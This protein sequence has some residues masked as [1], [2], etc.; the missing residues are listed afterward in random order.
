VRRVPWPKRCSPTAWAEWIIGSRAHS[1]RKRDCEH[2]LC[3]PKHVLLPTGSLVLF[4][5]Q[6]AYAAPA[7]QIVGDDS[8][9]LKLEAKRRLD[10]FRWHVQQLF[11]RGDEI[12]HWKTA[13][14]LVHRL[15]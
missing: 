13:M 15:R 11:G 12:L 3:D 5:S 7:V 14:P 2:Y 6:L 9:I 10:Q 4:H 1:N 8:A